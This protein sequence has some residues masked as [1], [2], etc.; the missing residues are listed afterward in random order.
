MAVS[1]YLFGVSV[2]KCIMTGKTLS[3]VLASIPVLNTFEFWLGIFFISGAA[4][5]FKSIE[6]TKALQIFIVIVRAVS[7]MLML[8]GAI[9]IMIQNGKVQ[10]FIP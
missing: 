4:F 7:I 3:K 8:V 5:S 9:I 2:S 6:K 1:I 10:S